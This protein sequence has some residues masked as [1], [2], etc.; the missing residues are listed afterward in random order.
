M[1][2]IN[3]QRDI[4]LEEREGVRIVVKRNKPTKEFHEIILSYTYCLISILLAHPSSPMSHK[5]IMTNE[6][7]VMRAA[8]R[9]GSR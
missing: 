3:W 8:G 9:W 6:G 5:D 2:F 1:Y 4:S 7:P